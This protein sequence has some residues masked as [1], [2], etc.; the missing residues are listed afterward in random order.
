[1]IIAL[2][3]AAGRL[4]EI[5]AADRAALAHAVWIDLV[6]PTDAEKEAVQRATGLHVASIAELQEIESSSRLNAE[7]GVL[8]LS[9]PFVQFPTRGGAKTRPLGFVL[10]RDRLITER[11]APSVSFDTV[12]Q[13]APRF[14]DG[15]RTGAHVLVTLLEV[16]VDRLA[17]QLEKIRDELDAISRAYLS[18]GSRL[19]SGAAPRGQGAATAAARHRRAP[20]NW[21]RASA[22]ACSPSAGSCPSSDRTRDWLAVDLAAAPRHLAA[23]HRLAQRL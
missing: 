3:P 14:E 5:D 13:R 4:A 18:G 1:M 2:A 21:P 9:M 23:G 12:H 15:H 20:A 16:I 22:T 7:D 10:D 8:S 6:D 19:R 11:F 17:D